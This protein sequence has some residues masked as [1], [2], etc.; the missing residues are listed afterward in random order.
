MMKIRQSMSL[1]QITTIYNFKRYTLACIG[2]FIRLILVGL[3][4]ISAPYGYAHNTITKTTSTATVSPGGIATYTILDDAVGTTSPINLIQVT[5]TLPIGFTYLSTTSITLLNVNSTRTAVVDPVA[6]TPTPTWGTFSNILASNGVAAGAFKIVFNA[7]VAP[8]TAC[9]AYTNTVKKVINATANDHTNTDAINVSSITVSGASPS[10]V[11]S[12]VANPSITVLPGGAASYT[13]TVTNTAAAGSCPATGVTLTD[14]LPVGFTYA[15]TGAIALNGGSLQ[16]STATPVVGATNP[17]WGNFTIPAGGSVNLSFTATVGA[18]VASGTYSNSA[19]TTTTASGASIT[20]F[21]GATSTADDIIVPP[22]PSLSKVFAAST[23]GIGQTTTLTFSINNTGSNAVTRSGLAFTDTLRSGLVIANPASPVSNNCGVPTFTAANASQPFT[24]TGISVAA[25]TI[26]TVTLSVR[27]TVLGAVTNAAADLSAV[28]GVGNAVTP[29]TI[30]VV[31]AGVTKT[32]GASS[33]VDGTTTTLIFTLSNGAGSPAQGG[34]VLGDTLPVGLQIN[35]ASPAV[36]YSAGC[37]GPANASYASITRVLSGLTGI[38]ITS[39]TSSCTV[40]V[41]GITNQTGVTGTCPN[42]AFTNLAS[43]I[44]TTNA[45]KASATDQCLSV[46]LAPPAG[47]LVNG[48]VYNDTNHNANLDLGESGTSIAGLFIKLTLS[49]AGICQSPALA[50]ATVNTSTGAYSLPNVVAGSYCLVLTNNNVLTNISPYL[51]PGWIGTEAPTGVRQITVATVAPAVQNFGLY[52]GSQLTALVFND[53]GSGGGTANDG[54]QN[55]SETGLGNITITAKSGAIT[56]DS[57]VSNGSGIVVLWLP[58]TTTGTVTLTTTLPS[59]Y[60]ATGGSAGNTTGSYVRPSVS[61]TFTSGLI[62]SGITFGLVPPNTLS[63]DG[64]QTA[65]PGTTIFYPHTFIAGSAG[66]VNFTTNAIAS[67][68]LAGWSEVIYRDTNCSG[69]FNNADPQLTTSI[70]AIAGQQICLLIKEFIPL[71]AALNAQNKVTLSAN[72][73]YSGSAAPAN[74]ILS[75][76]DTTTVGNGGNLQLTK[77]VQNLTQGSAYGTANNAL[78][79]NTLQYQ[80]T[81][82]NLGS[83]PLST[84]VINDNTPAFTTFISATCP[85]PASLP[86]SLTACNVS[87]QP[88]VGGQGT[89]QWTFIGSLASGSQTAVTF[90]VQVAP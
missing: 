47:V 45:N 58:A 7:T 18:G 49:S 73:T 83:D 2:Y 72:F 80:L 40:T 46:T 60:L 64:A 6:G 16:P 10:L 29:Q 3:L 65:Q 57:G 88:A 87:A 44:T 51:P 52:N 17:V 13:I 48:N 89:L 82:L 75:R 32:F 39:G 63:P 33:I 81:I 77:Q 9:G 24:A 36:T 66:L 53:N 68:L 21:N 20:P 86:P 74:S 34:I 42:A 85:I 54:I 22:V 55:G 15:S 30:T 41:A 71:G 23:V 4:F 27:G 67:P 70:T 28:S 14:A 5:D 62:Y 12:K 11:V 31:Q 8:T 61:F 56:I 84:L 79:G 69:L 1:V 35:S 19:S 26:C 37:S 76:V 25:G 38:A 50:S 59:G 90:Q 78:P 43:N